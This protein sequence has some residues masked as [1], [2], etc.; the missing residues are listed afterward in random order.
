M[1]SVD[2]IIKRKGGGG[3]KEE[4]KKERERQRDDNILWL[5]RE[6]V[7]LATKFQVIIKLKVELFGL[8]VFNRFGWAL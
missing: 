6:V 3:E 7:F 8:Y 4:G 1:I 5:F 2:E